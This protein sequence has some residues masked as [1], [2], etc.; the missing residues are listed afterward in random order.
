M[1]AK[2]TVGERGRK[3][4]RMRILSLLRISVRGT[5]REQE[6]QREQETE[7]GTD[8][9]RSKDRKKRQETERGEGRRQRREREKVRVGQQRATVKGGETR[10]DDVLSI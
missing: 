9:A 1:R 2:E 10:E 8:R 4:E 5:N 3:G 7:I 6:R